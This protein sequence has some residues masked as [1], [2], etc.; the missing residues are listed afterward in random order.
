MA[1]APKC[2][3]SC[4]AEARFPTCSMSGYA[5]HEG[6]E[7]GVASSRKRTA[8]SRFRVH[9]FQV[10]RMSPEVRK[11]LNGHQSRDGLGQDDVSSPVQRPQCWR[12]RD[13][14]QDDVSVDRSGPGVRIWSTHAVFNEEALPS[15]VHQL[16]VQSGVQHH[17]TAVKLGTVE[18]ELE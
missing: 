11:K 7:S 1:Q 2:A 18:P 17:T 13:S 15:G 4:A 6:P 3:R 5:Q 12:T 16:G 14:R 10:S 8:V 9:E